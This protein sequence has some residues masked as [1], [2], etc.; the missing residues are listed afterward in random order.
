MEQKIEKI[1][2]VLDSLKPFIQADGGDIE[3]VKYEDDYVYIKLS[4]ACAGCEFIDYTLEDNV[5]EAIK[6]EIPECKG[7]LNIDI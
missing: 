1:K 4:G 2:E 5:Y 7:V 3:F 6:E